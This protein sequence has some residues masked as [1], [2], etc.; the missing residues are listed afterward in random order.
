MI[1]FT[2]G[3][4]MRIAKIGTYT[5]ENKKWIKPLRDFIKLNGS[6]ILASVKL[7]VGYATLS[8][9]INGHQKISPLAINRL[10]QFNVTPK[11]K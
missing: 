10:E 4:Q 5:K 9:W 7:G 6:E 3:G 2:K 8:R 11:E 1:H